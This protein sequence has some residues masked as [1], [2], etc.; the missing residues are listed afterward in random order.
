M[1]PPMPDLEFL[2]ELTLFLKRE[3]A[4]PKAPAGGLPL[5]QRDFYKSTSSPGWH[6]VAVTSSRQGHL[7]LRQARPRGPSALQRVRGAEC[8]N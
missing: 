7:Y 1:K 6:W 2:K 5:E 4:V 3:W 8:R